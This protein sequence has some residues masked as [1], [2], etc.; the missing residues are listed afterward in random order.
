MK[1]YELMNSAQKRI[2]EYFNNYNEGL[3]SDEEAAYSIRVIA[4]AVFDHVERLYHCVWGEGYSR[5]KQAETRTEHIAYFT[6]DNGYEINNFKKI[7]DLRLGES[8]TLYECGIHSVT[9]IK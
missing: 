4:D 2:E 8:V 7:A 1:N 9:R 3:L 6:K 5:E